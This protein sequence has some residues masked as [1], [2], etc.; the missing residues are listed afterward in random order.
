MRRRPGFCSSCQPW[1]V[2]RASAARASCH[3]ARAC[4]AIGSGEVRAA[5]NAVMTPSASPA[6]LFYSSTFA[7][8]PLEKADLIAFHMGGSGYGQA[9]Q[10]AT[11]PPRPGGAGPWVAVSAQ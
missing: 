10:Y 2:S 11:L 8:A 3:V 9:R 5:L 7:P 4:F 1:T 6:E